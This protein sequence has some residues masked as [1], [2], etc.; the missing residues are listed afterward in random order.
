[1]KYLE[2]SFSVHMGKSEAY[3]DNWETIFGRKEKI[4]EESEDEEDRQEGVRG[5][6]SDDRDSS[7]W[8]EEAWHL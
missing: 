7:A 4:D 8:W 3:R 6:K 1:M 5:G 2:K